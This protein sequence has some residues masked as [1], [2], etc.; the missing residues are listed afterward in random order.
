VSEALQAA[1]RKI[2]EVA[3][4][5]VQPEALLAGT[6]SEDNADLVIA[7]ERHSLAPGARL[8]L[9]ALGKAADPLARAVER[10]LGERLTDGVIVTKEGHAV[11]GHPRPRG[12]GERLEVL[13][14]AHPV[15]D[16]RSL[17]AGQRIAAFL[18]DSRPTDLVLLLITGGASALAVIPRP[19]VTLDDLGQLTNLLLRAGAT[20]HELNVVRKHLD[21]LKGGGLIRLAAPARIRALLLSDVVGDSPS[22][23][24]SGPVT[25]DP[26][27]FADA[28][29]VLTQRGVLRETPAR[30]REIFERG[31]QGLEEETLKPGDPLTALATTAILASGATAVEAAAARAVEMGFE[32]KVLGTAVEGEAREVGRDIAA[33]VREV[34]TRARPVAPP[35]ALIW[36]GETTVT[37]RGDGRGGRNQELALAAALALDGLEEVCLVSIGT[38]GTDGPTDAAGAMIDGG[39]AV[40]ARA[41]HLDL[42]AALARNDAYPTLHALGALIHTGPTG[43]HVNDL[44]IALVGPLAGRVAGR[45]SDA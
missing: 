42:D 28:L 8:R 25:A 29:A 15:P 26:S 9:L 45:G 13:E 3:L 36:A 32:P 6:H 12:A 34:A 30:V 33:V 35:A 23:I 1:A 10:R 20:I 38:D 4:A 41:L 24:G 16:S 44:G 40:R 21:R 14:S 43:T 22:T 7:G 5:R 18:G 19:P 31:E 11:A 39:T 2:W 37:V 17:V 27:S